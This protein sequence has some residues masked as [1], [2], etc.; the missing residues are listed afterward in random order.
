MNGGFMENIYV[1]IYLTD[2]TTI[3]SAMCADLDEC[4]ELQIYS[5]FAKWGDKISDFK[6]VN[7][8]YPKGRSNEQ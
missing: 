4:I 5:K 7:I 6:W 8:K 3:K 2:G 1:W